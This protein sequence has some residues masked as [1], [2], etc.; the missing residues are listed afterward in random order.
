M[1][2]VMQWLFVSGVYLFFYAPILVLIV[3]SFNRDP[4]PAAWSGF[5]GQWYY[6]LFY[7]T[8]IWRAF[9]TSLIVA[10]SSMMLSCFFGLA[11]LYCS[12]YDAWFRRLVPFFYVNLLI[13]EVVLAIGLLALFAFIKLPLGL[14]TLVISHT[15]LGL[16]YVVPL[17]VVRYK[18]IDKRLV[19]A[20]LD[21]G[22][23]IGQTFKR[24][25]VPL[26]VPTLYGAGM[27]VFILSFDD[28]VLSY[29]CSGGGVQTISLAILGMLR[30]GIC[31]TVN[32]LTVVMLLFS[33]VCGSLFYWFNC[34]AQMW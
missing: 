30:S 3:F 13:P 2:Y 19:E 8:P 7:A 11:L 27:L 15:V 6:A 33:I 14:I 34:D 18:E 9:L 23:S 5:T 17:L 1:L 25:I 31:P 22:A 4:F 32:A 21:L 24:V 28:F 26:I 12:M 29:F 16:G 20:S 10:V